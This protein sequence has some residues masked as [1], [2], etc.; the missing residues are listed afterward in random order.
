MV[1]HA[2]MCILSEVASESVSIIVCFVTVT[3][4]SSSSWES[5]VHVPCS[6][7]QS[8]SSPLHSVWSIFP[9]VASLRSL[10][11]L[12]VTA[13]TIGSRCLA[14]LSPLTAL[15]ELCGLSEEGGPAYIHIVD[16]SSASSLLHFPHLRRLSIGAP[17]PVEGD[18]MQGWL[19][20]QRDWSHN[21]LS[22][23]AHLAQLRDLSLCCGR[24]VQGDLSGW[25]THLSSLQR[26]QFSRCYLPPDSDW[27]TEV[28]LPLQGLHSLAL[29]SCTGSGALDLSPLLLHHQGRQQWC[30]AVLPTVL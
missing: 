17:Y 21:S 11:V 29:I 8:D 23:L 13:A 6:A 27:F 28:L 2:V 5:D 22:C 26:L 30:T 14:M 25:L 16:A 24:V 15:Q 7:A 10:R 20:V 12:T 4:H 19:Q 3:A 9:A 18:L 1:C